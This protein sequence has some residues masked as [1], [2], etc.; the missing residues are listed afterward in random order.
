MLLE[1]FLIMMSSGK[2]SFS[3]WAACISGLIGKTVSKQAIFERMTVAWVAVC[4]Q[5]L[6]QSMRAQIAREVD[7]RLYCKFKRV[8]L[9]DS[10]SL[11]FPTC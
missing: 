7:A 6:E 11:L 5:L 2:N 4:R 1:S 3:S 10:T 9:Q 8:W